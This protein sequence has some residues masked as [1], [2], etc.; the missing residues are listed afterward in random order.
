[1]YVAAVRST[2]SIIMTTG[3][4]GDLEEE[5]EFSPHQPKDPKSTA[6]ISY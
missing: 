3:S 5:E 1:M 2:H 4:V 6:T